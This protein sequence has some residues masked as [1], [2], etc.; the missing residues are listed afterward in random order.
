MKT[1]KGTPN[2]PRLAI[3]RSHKHFYAQVID[4]QSS[5]TLF[6]CS[7]LDPTIKQQLSSGQNCNAAKIVG[8]ELGLVLIKNNLNQV[9]F[10]R[11]FHP[12]HGRIAAF[13]DGVREAGL[14][15]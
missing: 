7:T 3:F 14:K 10:D 1:I 13:A 9:V 8:K 15:F 12:F 4:D 6:S 11:R 5:K 2:R